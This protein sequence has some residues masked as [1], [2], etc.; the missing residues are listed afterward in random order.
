M[1]FDLDIIELFKEMIEIPYRKI[2]TIIG[3]LETEIEDGMD[4]IAWKK[5][6]DKHSRRFYQ[7]SLSIDF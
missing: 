3:F 1:A 5:N 7:Y 4:R 6:F 2:Y